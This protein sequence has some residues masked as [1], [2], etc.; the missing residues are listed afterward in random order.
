MTI[1]GRL[2]NLER[3]L[4]A[5]DDKPRPAVVVY[6]PQEAPEDPTKRDTWLKSQRP[7]DAGAVFFLPDNGRGIERAP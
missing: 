4:G 5:E 6:D 1:D 2:N 7:S 3:W